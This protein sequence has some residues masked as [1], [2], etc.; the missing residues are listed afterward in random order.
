MRVI[1][2]LVLVFLVAISEFDRSFAVNYRNAKIVW[3]EINQR[4]VGHGVPRLTL[5]KKLSQD[6]QLY[7]GKLAKWKNITYSDPT[8]KH[9]TESICKF[10]VKRGALTRCVQNWYRGVKYDFLDWRAKHFTA[11]IWRSSHSLGYGD[12]NI[13]ARQGV[14][15][16]RYSPPGNVKGLYTDNVPPKKQKRT[17]TQRIK[18]KKKGCATR[19]YNRCAILLSILVLVSTNWPN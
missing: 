1:S 14:F 11:M 17:Y 5:N 19:H 10:D 18:G 12:A 3:R 2:I 9:Y 16:I 6:C 13:N 4:R 7:A 15:V 8:N